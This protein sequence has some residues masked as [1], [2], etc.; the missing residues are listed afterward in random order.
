M[1]RPVRVPVLAAVGVAGCLLAVPAARGHYPMLEADQA[2][3]VPGQE[4]TVE[5][6]VGHPFA[7]D[8]FP[9]DKPLV[10][11]VYGPHGAEGQDLL[12]GMV[13]AGSRSIPRRRFKFTAEKEGDYVLSVRSLFSEP[14]QRR[15]EDYAKLIVHVRGGQLGWERVLGDPLEIVPL[16]RPYGLPVGATFR[17]RVLEHKNPLVDGTVE[18]ETYAHEDARRPFPE[19]AEYRRWEKTDPNGCFSVT[20]DQ[21]GWWLL[22]CA[23]DGGPGQQGGSTQVVKRAVMWVFVGKWD[24]AQKRSFAP[25]PGTAKPP[26]G[27]GPEEPPPAP[28]EEGKKDTLLPPPPSLEPPSWGGALLAWAA[29]L[30]AGVALLR[31]M[32]PA[33]AVALTA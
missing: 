23:T 9:C 7:N 1:P 32:Q 6:G 2:V 29:L 15:I 5:F 31:A 18:A 30:V 19:L 27:M 20:F 22:S 26:A 12:G 25:A 16:T 4:V 8:R 11:Q 24:P 14:P 33:E 21:P 10:A 28:P 17:G 3:V 13:E